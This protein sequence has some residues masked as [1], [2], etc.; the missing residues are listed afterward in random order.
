MEDIFIK[1]SSIYDCIREGCNVTNDKG[2]LF[3]IDIEEASFVN[4]QA[5]FVEYIHKS[6]MAYYGKKGFLYDWRFKKNDFS[7]LT[8]YENEIFNLPNIT[9]GGVLKIKKEIIHEYNALQSVVTDILIETNLINSL[10]HG[11]NIVPRLVP[12]S[13]SIKKRFRPL[14]TEK[15]HSD[16]W[17]SQKG[18]AVLSIPVAGDPSTTIEFCKPIGVS[19]DFFNSLENYDD[20]FERGY[21][22][23][24]EFLDFA[25]FKMIHIFDQLCVHRT[26]KQAGNP[27]ISLELCI[28]ADHEDSLFLKDKELSRAMQRNRYFD[29]SKLKEL[30]KGIKITTGERMKDAEKYEQT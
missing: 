6:L 10:T 22:E 26:L 30:G 25:K 4:L 24:L 7:F 17:A 14:S 12:G 2:I 23:N 9:P 21:L 3:N 27:R 8:V 28:A 18:D 16:V 20:A 1:R 5:A 19:A 13:T 11:Q 29:K 15:Y